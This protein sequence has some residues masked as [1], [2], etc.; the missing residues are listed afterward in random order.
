MTSRDAIFERYSCRGFTSEK[1]TETQIDELL[2]A[3][4]ASPTGRNIREQR[5]N[6][7]TDEALIKEISDICYARMDEEV[8]ARMAS[9]G[10]AN[11]FYGAPA[12]LVISALP[13]R[14]DELD[15]GIAAQSVCLAAHDM[16]LATCIIAMSRPAFDKARTPDMGVKLGFGEDERYMVSIAIGHPEVTKEPHAFD[17]DHVRRF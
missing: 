17:W 13:S 1:L 2:K 8:K 3:G 5:F 14:Y 4:L 7:I 12:V 16:G 6:M 9:R 11:L 10:A 15:A